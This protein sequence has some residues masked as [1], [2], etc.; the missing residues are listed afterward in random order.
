MLVSH[1]V[2]YTRGDLYLVY[3]IITNSILSW[4][5]RAL[6]RLVPFGLKKIVAMA[7]SGFGWC[8]RSSSP[9]RQSL[10]SSCNTRF[11]SCS[12]SSLIQGS[13]NNSAAVGRFSGWICRH[14]DRKAVQPSNSAE[15][16]SGMKCTIA[17]FKVPFCPSYMKSP[18]FS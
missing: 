18:E 14:R 16:R 3:T 15:G 2:V 4:S 5:R 7:L 1:T 11:V 9:G 17:P 8:I 13:C 6:D 12:Q 10:Y